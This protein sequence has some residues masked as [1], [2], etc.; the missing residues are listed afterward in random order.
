MWDSPHQLPTMKG[1]RY[2][3]SEN[4][5]LLATVPPSG[6]LGVPSSKLGA[7][8]KQINTLCDFA[9]QLDDS[10]K[11]MGKQLDLQND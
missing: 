5:A 8:T 9:S 11:Q 3:V 7:P 10:G 1:E 4:S 6:G 2:E